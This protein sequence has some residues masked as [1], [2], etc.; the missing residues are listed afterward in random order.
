MIVLNNL[1]IKFTKCLHIF[2]WYNRV[3]K[4]YLVDSGYSN[5]PRFLAP[6]RNI[7]YH[8][9]DTRRRAGGINGPIELFNYSHASLRNCI[10]RCFGVLNA[11]FPILRYMTNFSLIRQR[12]IAMCCYVLHNFIRLHNREDPLFDRYGVDGVMPSSDSDS[13]DDAPSSSGTTQN[14]G[15]SGGNDNNF[16]NNTLDHIIF[17]MYLNHN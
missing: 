6:F 3:G 5:K 7:L 1:L 13:E 8:L 16:V 15:G 12:E 4:Y 14:Q 9:H 10:E 2:I 11:R 17:K